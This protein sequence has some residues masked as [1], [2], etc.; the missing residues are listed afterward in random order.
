MIHL[1]LFKDGIYLFPQ[2]TIGF[3]KWPLEFVFQIRFLVFDF[4]FYIY[5]RRK[6]DRQ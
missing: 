5:L 1:S 4:G 3:F 2:V 6:Y